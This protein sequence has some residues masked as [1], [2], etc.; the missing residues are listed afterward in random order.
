MRKRIRGRLKE[1]QVISNQLATSNNNVPSVSDFGGART[2]IPRFM[3][4]GGGAFGALPKRTQR[5]LGLDERRFVNYSIDQLVD[6]LTDVHPDVSFALWNFLRIGNS[7]YTI[8][9]RRLGSGKPY[10]QAERDIKEFIDRL[11]MPN[12]NQFEKS[13]SFHKVLNQL[14]LSAVTRGAVALELVLLPGATDVAFLAPVDPATID[15]QFI[16]DRFVPFQ[17][18]LKRSLDVPTFIYEGLDERIDDP[19]GR[20]PLLGALSMVLFQLQV[21]NDIKAVVHNQGYPRLDIKVLEEV[22]LARM[23]IAIRNNEQLKQEWLNNK[24][25]EIIKMYSQLEPDD[26]FVHFDSIDIDMVGGKGSGGAMLD[27]QKLMEAIDNLIMSGL[28]TL[29]TILGRRSTG[30][31]ESFAKMEIKLYLQGVK[32]IQDLVASVMVRALTIFLNLRGKQGIVEFKFKPVEIRTELEQ[33]QFQQIALQNYAYMR[34]QGWI[35]QE[36]A[37]QMAV[38]HAPVGEPDWEH[39]GKST[40][41]NKDGSPTSGQKDEKGTSAPNN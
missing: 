41:T 37:A 29:S 17:D 14:F 30:N 20:S 21:L 4:G 18:N 7:G 11:S 8:S 23:P 26:T 5:D 40:I 38:G 19:Y 16:N 28:K 22:L 12:M 36:E 35:S 10:P 32:A 34:D 9:V 2:T 25:N 31:T 13:R 1:R 27:P 39:L 15:F 3:N 6:I 33:A 24:L